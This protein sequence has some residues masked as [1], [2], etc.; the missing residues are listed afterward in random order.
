MH[1]G[2]RGSDLLQYLLPRCQWKSRVILH[3]CKQISFE[4]FVNENALFLDLVNMSAETRMT[5]KL[6]LEIFKMLQ[7]RVGDRLHDVGRLLTAGKS[8]QLAS[9]SYTDIELTAQ[10]RR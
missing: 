6:S 8:G 2:Q 5:F 10:H 4:V 7:D 9:V 1:V 3:Q